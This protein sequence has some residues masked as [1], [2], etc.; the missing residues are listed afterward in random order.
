MNTD[1]KDNKFTSKKVAIIVVLILALAI[2]FL[3]IMNI[4]STSNGTTS[5]SSST[6]TTT[7]KDITTTT[8]SNSTTTTIISSTSTIQGNVTTTVTITRRN[9]E[10]RS[11]IEIIDSLPPEIEGKLEVK[12][13]IQ[14]DGHMQLKIKNIGNEPFEPNPNLVIGIHLYNKHGTEKELIGYGI[15][16]TIMP[17]E[18]DTMNAMSLTAT[19][20]NIISYRI[21]IH[22]L[23]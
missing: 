15:D 11:F 20:E 2:G 4:P 13:H 23:D 12:V 14:E 3:A 8:S 10:E 18:T 7:K 19:D 16:K 17:G 21:K 5:S 1:R 9:G 6:T 22:I